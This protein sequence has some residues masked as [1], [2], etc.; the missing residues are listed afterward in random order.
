MLIES[1]FFTNRIFL[2]QV[3]ARSEQG[4]HNARVPRTD[5]RVPAAALERVAT[6]DARAAV[7]AAGGRGA[8]LGARARRRHAGADGARVGSKGEGRGRRTE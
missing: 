4:S 5:D 1:C 7:L 6:R 8:L 2:L 3:Y